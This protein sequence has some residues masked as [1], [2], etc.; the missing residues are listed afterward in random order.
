MQDRPSASVI[1][2]LAIDQLGNVDPASARAK[3]EMRMAI[4]ALQLVRRE[5]E[6]QPA[7][8]ADELERLVALLGEEG[9][10]EALNRRLCA[11]IREGAMS[12]NSPGVAAHARATTMAKLAIDQPTYAAYRRALET[13]KG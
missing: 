3:F 10:L 4:A 1:L 2:D 12:F 11:R 7:S 5:M 8:D 9:D 13:A 6:L